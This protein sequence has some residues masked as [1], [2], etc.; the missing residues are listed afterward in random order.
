MEK[1]FKP[2]TVKYHAAYERHMI[3]GEV[4]EATEISIHLGKLV[5]IRILVKAFTQVYH[6]SLYAYV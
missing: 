3:R 4:L 2:C 1:T 6:M 5:W